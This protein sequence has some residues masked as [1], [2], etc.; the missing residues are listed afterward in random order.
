MVFEFAAIRA[1]GIRHRKPGPPSWLLIRRSLGPEPELKCYVSN[2]GAETPLST[3][4]LVACMRCQVEEFLEDCKSY[5]GMTQ[6][7]TRSY[8]GWHHHMSLVAMAHL[9]VT[10]TRRA[11]GKKRRS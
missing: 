4:A 5:L 1:W 6:Y 7:E 9:F 8:V 11:L 2:A 10:L 3:L